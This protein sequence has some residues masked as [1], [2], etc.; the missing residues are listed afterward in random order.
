MCVFAKSGADGSECAFWLTD[1]DELR[2][3]HMG[4]GSGSCLACV[5]ADNAVD[6]LRLIAIGYDEIC[7][8]EEFL[9][10]PNKGSNSL[11]V[12]PNV[13][14]Q[15]WVKSTFN[16]DIPKTALEIVKHPATFYHSSSKSEDEFFN[17]S[18]KFVK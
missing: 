7:W 10:P 3:V 1:K 18:G 4:S 8:D 13:K 12:K 2:I 9:F 15:N 17:W 6:L 11:F 16:T 14:F 5:L